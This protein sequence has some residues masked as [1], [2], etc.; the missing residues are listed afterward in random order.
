MALPLP[1]PVQKPFLRAVSMCTMERRWNSCASTGSQKRHWPYTAV[2]LTTAW[3]QKLKQGPGVIPCVSLTPIYVLQGS[4]WRRRY[5]NYTYHSSELQVLEKFDICLREVN[6]A[7]KGRTRQ[8]L[9]HE[10]TVHLWKPSSWENTYDH[11]PT[12]FAHFFLQLCQ[13]H[14]K[15]VMVS[16]YPKEAGVRPGESH[17]ALQETQDHT[18]FREASL[19][20]RSSLWSHLPSFCVSQGGHLPWKTGLQLWGG[21]LQ[22]PTL[23]RAVHHCSTTNAFLELWWTDWWHRP[24]PR[25]Q[26]WRYSVPWRNSQVLGVLELWT[27]EVVPVGIGIANSKSST[28]TTPL[29]KL[30]GFQ[31]TQNCILDFLLGRAN[32]ARVCQQPWAFGRM[33]KWDVYIYIYIIFLFIFVY[34]YIE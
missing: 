18:G 13:V 29:V 17:I 22:G 30:A 32:C 5:T 21:Q 16:P 4:E 31:N 10:Q 12:W 9:T 33:E 26:V 28:S 20:F 24:H 8:G 3:P 19:W 25:S 11:L 34:I 1:K 15:L 2:P 27:P 6:L 23:T 7:L 14:T